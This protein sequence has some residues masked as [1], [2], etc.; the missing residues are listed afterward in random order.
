MTPDDLLDSV[1]HLANQVRDVAIAAADTDGLPEVE[2]VT[3]VVILGIGAGRVAGDVIAAICELRGSVPVIATGG[4]CPSWVSASTLAIALSD[5]VDNTAPIE[6]VEEA[7]SA[8]A[9]LLAVAAPG[10]FAEACVNWEI[11][12]VLI[13]PDAGPAAG[14][15]VSI[16]PVLVLLERLRFA[17]GMSGAVSNTASQLSD[18]VAQLGETGDIDNLA[19]VLD[20]RL[21]IVTGA[22]AVG[23]HAARR[24]VQELDR[25][26]EVA[27]VRRRL[28][29]GPADV[30]SGVRLAASTSNGAVLIL[31]RHD[32]EPGGLD[33][34]V[35][36]LSDH[37]DNIHSFSAAGDG[38]LAQLLDLVLLA[39]A[40]AA[41]LLRRRSVQ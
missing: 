35:A 39:D 11:P 32:F 3:E 41:A 2:G 5:G 17:K 36:L 14:L 30:A 10:T 15:G 16:V 20:G 7:R 34:G 13:D 19:A 6:A 21:A 4:R 40:V 31:L 8:G 29:T 12:V 23:K 9:R 28:P 22:G 26:G 37:F 25:V 24:W 33:A 18:R 27:A 1:R 38:P